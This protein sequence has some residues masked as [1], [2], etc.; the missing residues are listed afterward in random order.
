MENRIKELREAKGISQ[1]KIAEDLDIPIRTYKRYEQG[2]TEN[3]PIF[4]KIAE[5]LGVTIEQLVKRE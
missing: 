5:Y 4:L 3:L 1:I 2:A